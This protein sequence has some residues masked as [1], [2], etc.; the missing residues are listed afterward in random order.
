MRTG[1]SLRHSPLDDIL[2]FETAP[3]SHHVILH[4]PT[5]RLDFLGSLNEIETEIGEGFFRTHRAYLVALN[6]SEEIDLKHNRLLVGG[7]E[8]L[9]SRTAKS[10]LL[11]QGVLL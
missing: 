2:F 8:C 1:D 7:R 9:L 11:K 3:K 5:S 10:A 4:T 6:K